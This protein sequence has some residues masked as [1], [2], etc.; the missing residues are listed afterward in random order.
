M[1]RQASMAT[2]QQALDGVLLAAPDSG[3]AESPD[4]SIAPGTSASAPITDADVT[5]ED[6]AAASVETLD[7]KAALARAKIERD[8]DERAQE[9][10]KRAQEAQAA[11]DRSAAAT[12]DA[13]QRIAR[14]T[15]VRLSS[16]PQPGSIM[17]PLFLLL[18]FF[19][20]LIPVN[21]HTRAVWLWLVLSG[22]AAIA[23][24][25]GGNGNTGSSTTVGSGVSQV[26]VT[27][28]PPIIMPYTTASGSHVEDL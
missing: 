5:P 10:D 11:F 24:S 17:L 15:S 8:E 18:I 23:D 27:L 9:E 14:G 7:G 19:F 2:I 22:N 16:I 25:P 13:V 26:P 28:P 12:V 20:L 6:E 3:Q 21:G 4:I 1:A